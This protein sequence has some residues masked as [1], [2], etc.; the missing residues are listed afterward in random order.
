[1][2]SVTLFTNRGKAEL[3]DF[4]LQDESPVGEDDH[5]QTGTFSHSDERG[6]D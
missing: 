1:M 3:E 4:P 5:T 6:C 2:S